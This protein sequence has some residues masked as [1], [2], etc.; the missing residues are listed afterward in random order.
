MHFP[1]GTRTVRLSLADARMCAGLWPSPGAGRGVWHV[2]REQELVGVCIPGRASLQNWGA[3]L[4]LWGC[5]RCVQ[6]VRALGLLGR[7][8]LRTR[9]QGGDVGAPGRVTGARCGGSGQWT[10]QRSPRLALLRV[11][12]EGPSLPPHTVKGHTPSLGILTHLVHSMKWGSGLELEVSLG[13]LP[14]PGA[15]LGTH[16]LSRLL[17]G[18]AGR[19]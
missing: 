2:L 17:G 9:P 4:L 11:C 7:W 14:I 6:K 16:E 12:P 1:L 13:T 3:T 8:G 19:E 5:L 10:A 18:G 15:A